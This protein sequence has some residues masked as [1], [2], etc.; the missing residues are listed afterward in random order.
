M[1]RKGGSLDSTYFN[2][3]ARAAFR[4]A[5]TKA[6]TY[7]ID[8]RAIEVILPPEASKVPTERILPRPMREVLTNQNYLKRK[9]GW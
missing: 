9:P 6:W 5:D 2:D 8:T 4:E 3:D 1:Q 7:V